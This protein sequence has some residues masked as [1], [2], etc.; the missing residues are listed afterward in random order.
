[1]RIS[2]HSLSRVVANFMRAIG[3]RV[4]PG[5]IKIVGMKAAT[6]PLLKSFSFL[7]RCRALSRGPRDRQEPCPRIPGQAGAVACRTTEYCSRGA[8]DSAHASAPRIMS[9]RG[10]SVAA[11]GRLPGRPGDRGDSRLRGA[12]RGGNCRDGKAF[13][14]GHDCHEHARLPWL[15]KMAALQYGSEGDA[16]GTLH[17]TAGLQPGF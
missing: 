7:W 1:M 11:T 13:A 16:A 12:S 14:G 4:P 2:S 3:C 6:H 9:Q 10:I 15:A 8:R 5:A 17:N